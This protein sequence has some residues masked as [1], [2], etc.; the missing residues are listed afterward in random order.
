MEL[1]LNDFFFSI[2]DRTETIWVTLHVF[3]AV[4]E[5]ANEPRA[6][7]ALSLH[8]QVMIRIIKLAFFNI[9]SFMFDS[10][11]EGI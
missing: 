2:L 9:F 5:V 7:V 8:I 1:L 10:L 3:T 6:L 11:S 4:I